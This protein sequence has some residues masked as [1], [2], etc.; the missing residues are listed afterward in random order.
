[1]SRVLGRPYKKSTCIE[2]CTN[3]ST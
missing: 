1:M 2:I 3:L